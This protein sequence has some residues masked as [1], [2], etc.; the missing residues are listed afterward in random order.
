M[1]KFNDKQI[2]PASDA[3]EK[4]KENADYQSDN[5]HRATLVSTKKVQKHCQIKSS[6]E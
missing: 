3:G 1:Q 2:M 4:K 5:K 6:H